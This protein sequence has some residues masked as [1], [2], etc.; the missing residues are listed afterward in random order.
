M[1]EIRFWQYHPSELQVTY[2]FLNDVMG[3]IS[4]EQRFNMRPTPRLYYDVTF[5]LSDSEVDTVKTLI[6]A[7][8][9]ETD[10][11]YRNRFYMPRFDLQYPAS[12]NVAGTE[13]TVDT[14][15]IDTEFLDTDRYSY[16]ITSDHILWASQSYTS[17]TIT[18]DGTYDL[19]I[20]GDTEGFISPVS[21]VRLVEAPSFSRAGF[22]DNT[23]TLRLLDLEYTARTFATTPFSLET[24]GRA[25]LDK[26][27]SSV[28]GFSNTI[29]FPEQT[30]D[31]GTGPISYE[32]VVLDLDDLSDRVYT[33]QGNTEYD[34]F[35]K[36]VEFV[37]G[38]HRKFYARDTAASV[39]NST[40]RLN[41]DEIV[42]VH[43]GSSSGTVSLPFKLLEGSDE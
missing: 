5:Q 36:F 38:M 22:D 1:P 16:Q 15:V 27:P 6:R 10:S 3:A 33:F 24:D 23:V 26:D 40:F 2:S 13:F 30:I 37:G 21:L 39:S 41:T 25:I 28:S 29:V 17:T 43:E 14:T 11:A 42:F 12:L 31:Y 34:L 4:G 8:M 9:N 18:V 35:L 20:Y 7:Q 32:R 19:S